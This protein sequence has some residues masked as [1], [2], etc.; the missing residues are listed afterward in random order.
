MWPLWCC[1]S[2]FVRFKLT[3][4]LCDLYI[5][6]LQHLN[7]YSLCIAY[8]S[9]SRLMKGVVEFWINSLFL[10]DCVCTAAAHFL[11][12]FAIKMNPPKSLLLF[13]C[14]NLK[15]LD[16]SITSPSLATAALWE[17][18]LHL[19]ETQALRPCFICTCFVHTDSTLW[20]HSPAHATNHSPEKSSTCPRAITKSKSDVANTDKKVNISRVGQPLALLCWDPNTQLGL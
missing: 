8:W 20:K 6:D 16:L 4:V 1:G 15:H 12:Q 17:L 5:F 18:A 13:H 3:S 11:T 7:I 19:G 9:K 2:W 10:C 14:W